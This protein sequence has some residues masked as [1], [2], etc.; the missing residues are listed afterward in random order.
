MLTLFRS[1]P[2]EPWFSLLNQLKMFLD[3]RSDGLERIRI[4]VLDTGL[5]AAKEGRT[6]VEV[7]EFRDFVAEHKRRISNPAF[8]GKVTTR[9]DAV[10]HGTKAVNLLHS[11]FP[12]AEL[13]V[14]R[15]FQTGQETEDTKD[16]ILKV[17]QYHSTTQVAT[18]YRCLKL[19][20]TTRQSNGRKK[21]K[22]T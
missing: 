10:G 2:S 21:A 20:D 14:G 12:E 6:V 18:F 9:I 17:K 13:Y 3:G 15:V 1:P 5:E 16:C 11:I 22:C 8:D 7:V 19:T 4:A